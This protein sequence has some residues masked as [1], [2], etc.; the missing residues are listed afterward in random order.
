MFAYLS[1]GRARPSF[2]PGRP[3]AAIAAALALAAVLPAGAAWAAG[4]GRSLRRAGGS[5][6][7]WHA[8]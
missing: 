1:G 4:P 5:G 7:H 3:Q 6:G 8:G 2:W